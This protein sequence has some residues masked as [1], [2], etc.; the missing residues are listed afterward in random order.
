MPMSPISEM[1]ASLVAEHAV[2]VRAIIQI[3]KAIATSNGDAGKEVLHLTTLLMEHCFH[4]DMELFPVVLNHFH[5]LNK[6]KQ[7]TYLYESEGEK[8]VRETYGSGENGVMEWNE[9]QSDHEL[10]SE[11]ISFAKVTMEAFEVLTEYLESKRDDYNIRIRLNDRVLGIIHTLEVRIEYE[12]ME[13]FPRI[14]NTPNFPKV[15]FI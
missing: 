5:Q 3:K 2:I 14:R 1:L 10:R 6:S 15:R 8:K 13:L 4:E 12:E 11:L 9:D 7:G